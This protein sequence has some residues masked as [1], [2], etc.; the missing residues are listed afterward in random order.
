MIEPLIVITN[1]PISYRELSKK[2]EVIYV[3]KHVTEVYKEVRDKIHMGHR[4]LTHPLLSSIKPNETPYRT[5][6]VSK[7]KCEKCDY[8]SLM[9]IENSMSTVDKFLN[10]SPIPEYPQSIMEDFQVIDFDLI[11]K[12]IN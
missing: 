1:N 9:L 4:L 6:C 8:K 5:I 2:F 12:A 11:N 7:E 3:E 10:M